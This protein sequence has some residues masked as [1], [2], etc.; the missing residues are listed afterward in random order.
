MSCEENT[1]KNNVNMLWKMYQ[2]IDAS[3]F[4]FSVNV[5]I[6]HNERLYEQRGLL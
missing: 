3:E 2:N 6:K 5:M 4:C 1:F